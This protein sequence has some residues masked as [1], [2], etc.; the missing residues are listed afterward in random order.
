MRRKGID[1]LLGSV[2]I[3]SIT[4]IIAGIVMTWLTTMTHNQQMAITN[5]SEESMSCNGVLQVMEVYLDFSANR[6]RVFVSNSGEADNIVSAKL[7]TTK[8][9]EARNITAFPLT[10][11]QGEIKMIEFNLTGNVTACANFSKVLVSTRCITDTWSQ[12]PTGC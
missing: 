5:K 9:T 7:V 1:A 2:I 11:L 10:I 4:V 3:I 8:G 6:S 12:T